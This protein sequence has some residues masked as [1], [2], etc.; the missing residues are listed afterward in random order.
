MSWNIANFGAKKSTPH[1]FE[2]VTQAANLFE[3]DFLGILEVMAFSGESIGEEIGGRLA[4]FGN[5]LYA[6]SD[7]FVAHS[8]QYLKMWNTQL[9]TRK[10]EVT[11]FG[12]LEFPDSN[13]RPPYVGRFNIGG[14]V[15]DF[16]IALYHAPGPSQKD[17][18]TAGCAN[19]AKIPTLSVG[20]GV[21]LGDFNVSPSDP[22]T[23]DGLKAFGP[24][25]KLGFRQGMVNK[26]TSLKQVKS[27]SDNATISDCLS[28]QYDNVFHQ[29]PSGKGSFACGAIDTISCAVESS[30][31][32]SKEYAG[33]LA[34]YY[35]S[36]TKGAGWKKKSFGSI[37]EAFRAYRGTVSDHLPVLAV[38]TAP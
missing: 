2:Y 8:E 30:S 5:W 3:A 25:I 9:I 17:K 24:L 34:E 20:Y 10:D 6:D 4:N 23:G 28:S 19:L 22:N 29:L 33:L 16:P 11:D 18:V 27:V 7:Q 38:W 37:A 32:Y 35:A 31:L 12:K 13:F 15:S 21:V 26:A 14:V 1:F 36:T